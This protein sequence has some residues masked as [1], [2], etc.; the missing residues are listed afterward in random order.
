MLFKSK[1]RT[2]V[3]LVLSILLV[4]FLCETCMGF[5]VT[6]RSTNVLQ[7]LGGV[8]LLG[9]VYLLGEAGGEWINSKDKL[10]QPLHRRAL[11][12]LL[13]LTFAAFICFLFYL[14]LLLVEQLSG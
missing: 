11:N 13:L 2:I 8:I 7:W 9:A 3:L 10:T 1:L 14:V 4:G 6:N 12:L 5:P